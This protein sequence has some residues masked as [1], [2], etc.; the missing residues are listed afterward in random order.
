MTEAPAMR[1]D[2]KGAMLPLPG[3]H[4]DVKVIFRE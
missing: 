4:A 2:V 1:C 3:E